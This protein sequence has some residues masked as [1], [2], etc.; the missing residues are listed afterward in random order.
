MVLSRSTALTSS[1]S[2]RTVRA[3][4]NQR[5]FKLRVF[6]RYGPR[7]PLSGVSVPEMLDAAHI[8]GHALGGSDDPRNG[9]PLNV[10]IHRAFDAGLSAFNPDTLEGETWPGGPTAEAMGICYPAGLKDL[11]RPPHRDALQWRYES[12]SAAGPR[13]MGRVSGSSCTPWLVGD[14]A[15][16]SALSL[17][18]PFLGKVS[19]WVR[20]SSRD[21]ERAG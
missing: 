5:M 6:Q 12:W 8:M 21:C 2:T 19:I 9:L 7:C 4:P 20:T 3:R 14:A 1:G 16:R 13:V 11:P 10:A 17:R 15:S 18:G